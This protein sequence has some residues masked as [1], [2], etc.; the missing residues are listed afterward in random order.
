MVDMYSVSEAATRLGLDR[1]QIRRLLKDGIIEG[2]K[3]GH[4]WVVFSLDY[5]K[6]KFGVGRKP[7]GGNRMRITLDVTIGVGKKAARNKSDGLIIQLLE[8]RA[9]TMRELVEEL[10]FGG[11]MSRSLAERIIKSAVVAGVLK[12]LVGF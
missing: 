1:S 8:G 2:K 3:L 12:A 6:Q 4:Y 7:K 5:K 9:M 11:E 10:T